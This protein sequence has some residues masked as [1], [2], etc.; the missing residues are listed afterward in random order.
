MTSAI[1]LYYAPEHFTMPQPEQHLPDEHFMQAICRG[2]TSALTPLYT[3]YAGKLTAYFYRMLGED[4]EIAMDFCQELFS[5]ILEKPQLYDPQRP[6]PTW[7]FSLAA[8]MCKNEY[9]R[10]KVRQN[11]EAL[12]NWQRYTQSEYY[13]FESIDVATFMQHLSEAL[14]EL[15]EVRRTTFLLRFQQGLSVKEI[16]EI[17][18]TTEG[19][20][21]SRLFYLN[22]ELA[23][24]LKHVKPS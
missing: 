2:N 18:N 11:P 20:V 4:R 22:R 24:K 6:F 13:S 12:L 10:R 16:A 19:T 15:D 5:K 21:K 3:R 23:Q 9:R 17:T 7:L 14:K 1:P 8:N